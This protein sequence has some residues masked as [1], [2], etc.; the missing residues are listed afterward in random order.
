NGQKVWTSGAHYSDV[1]EIITKTST[2]KPKHKS[3]TMFLVDMRAP[4][5]E[6]RPLRQMTGG[7]SFN[8]GF[9]S[10]VRVPDSHRLRSVDRGGGGWG[11]V[12]GGAHAGERGGGGGRRRR[13]RLGE[14]AEAA[15]GDR[16]PLRARRRPAHPPGAGRHLHPPHRGPVHEPAGDGED[17]RRAGA[18]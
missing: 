18:G 11:G 2:D 10:D 13:G 15:A 5:I 1:G 17:P 7:A 14:G 3:L 4:G 6:V 12:G 8:E 16:R 9:F